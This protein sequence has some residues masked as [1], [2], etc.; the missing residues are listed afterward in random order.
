[1]FVHFYF[2]HVQRTLELWSLNYSLSDWV[3]FGI[4]GSGCRVPYSQIL[5]LNLQVPRGR[6]QKRTSSLKSLNYLRKCQDIQNFY[7]ACSQV[8]AYAQISLLE[9]FYLAN[10]LCMQNKN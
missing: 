5:I 8:E 10:Y 7:F 6:H 2:E 3:R 1:M 4:P 9:S